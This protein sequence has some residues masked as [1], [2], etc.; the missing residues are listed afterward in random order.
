MFRYMLI[1]FYVCYVFHTYAHI[2]VLQ[3]ARHITP[4]DWSFQL[5]QIDVRIDRHIDRQID[6]RIDKQID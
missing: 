4:S 1:I 5:T 6:R 2:H 3:L